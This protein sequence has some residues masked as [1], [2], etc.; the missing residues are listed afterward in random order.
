MEIGGNNRNTV[1]LM[2]IAEGAHSTDALEGWFQA[3]PARRTVLDD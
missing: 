2:R 3:V 1:G